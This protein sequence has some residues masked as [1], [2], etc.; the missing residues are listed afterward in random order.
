MTDQRH[1]GI[2]MLPTLLDVFED[3]VHVGT[4][5]HVNHTIENGL[6]EFELERERKTFRPIRY[7]AR[8]VVLHAPVCPVRRRSLQRI[9]PAVRMLSDARE[10]VD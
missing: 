2:L 4:A 7:L 5:E 1:V 10:N 3:G 8:C 9:E 6:L